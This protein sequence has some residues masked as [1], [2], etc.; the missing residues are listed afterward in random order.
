[1]RNQC[2]YLVLLQEFITMLHGHL[3]VKMSSTLAVSQALNVSSTSTAKLKYTK[4]LLCFTFHEK[5][6]KYERGNSV[7]HI[8]NNLKQ[9]SNRKRELNILS[10][11]LYAKT[12]CSH[13][14]SVTLSTAICQQPQQGVACGYFRKVIRHTCRMQNNGKSWNTTSYCRPRPPPVLRSFVCLS[15]FASFISSSHL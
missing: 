14:H 1:M 11:E 10:A 9:K 8:Y 15:H 13:C 2:I 4:I 6:L 5:K 12:S 3:N 7:F